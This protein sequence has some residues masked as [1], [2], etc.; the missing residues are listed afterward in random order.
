MPSKRYQ[1][2]YC[3]YATNHST[4]LKRHERIHTGEKPFKCTFA[5]CGKAFAQS[6]DLKVHKR[7]HTGE[8]PFLCSFPGCDKVFSQAANLKT[9][10]RIHTG[11]RPYECSYPGW[12]KAFSHLATL[13]RHERIHTG[14][15]PFKCTFSGCGKAFAEA[16]DL[17]VHERIHT[18]EKPFLCSFPGCGKAFAQLSN[19]QTHERIHTGEKPYK[20]SFSGCG[21]AFAPLS[22]LQTHERIHTG[23]KPYKCSFSGCGKAFAQLSNLQTHN[24]NVHIEAPTRQNRVPERSVEADQVMPLCRFCASSEW[25]NNGV[26]CVK[27]G[28]FC[29]FSCAC[30]HSLFVALAVH[31][32]NL[33]DFLCD[34][35]IGEESVSSL[36]ELLFP[37]SESVVL[38][39]TSHR[40]LTGFHRSVGVFVEGRVCPN[41]IVAIMSLLPSSSLSYL[42]S[43]LPSSSLFS[44]FIRSRSSSGVVVPEVSSAAVFT[45]SDG[46]HLDTWLSPLTSRLIRR[47]SE[48]GNCVGRDG[49]D[50]DGVP[51]IEVRALRGI[52]DEELVLWEGRGSVEGSETALTDDVSELGKCECGCD[53]NTV[54][55]SEQTRSVVAGLEENERDVE[56][57]EEA[58]DDGENAL[59]LREN[60]IHWILSSNG[61]EDETTRREHQRVDIEIGSEEEAISVDADSSA[62]QSSNESRLVVSSSWLRTE[63]ISIVEREYLEERERR[64][65]EVS[66]LLEG[67]EWEDVAN[68][69][70]DE[71]GRPVRDTKHEL[72][73]DRDPL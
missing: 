35:W 22:N 55:L 31:A 65:I 37:R 50:E 17:K 9:H 54:D 45:R 36:A 3:D 11:E 49:V 66:K 42:L 67:L 61:N 56:E 24:Q 51:I 18:G 72:F 73:L 69:L 38:R 62:A 10:Q 53:V 7:I 6:S 34:T 5:G 52:E 15:K 63:W 40:S 19:L 68:L 60:L 32:V 48:C 20:C 58:S 59:R 44:P 1:C 27:C 43:L 29:H 12:N 4:S 26:E 70:R 30:E 41:E 33:D 46:V 2:L 57:G 47:S 64:R 14:E 8:K 39:H 71:N 28:E 23:E 21:K 13:L 16:S 25:R